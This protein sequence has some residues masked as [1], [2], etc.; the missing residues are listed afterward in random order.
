[1]SSPTFSGG[2]AQAVVDLVPFVAVGVAAF[3]V[4]LIVVVFLP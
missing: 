2:V 1:M 4:V 3:V